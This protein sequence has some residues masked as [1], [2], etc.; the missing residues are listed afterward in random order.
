MTDRPYRTAPARH[1]SGGYSAVNVAAGQFMD[2]DGTLYPITNWFDG[3][4]GEC[5]RADAVVCVAGKDACWFSIDLRE[6]EGVT[7]Q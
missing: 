7:T 6:F 2:A 1:F 5:D 4:G 3:E